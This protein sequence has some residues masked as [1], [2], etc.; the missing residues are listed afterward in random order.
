VVKAILL[1]PEARGDS[2]S[3]PT[4]GRLRHPAQFIAGVP[5]AFAARSA[6]GQTASDGC[7]NPQSSAMGMDV[8][9]PP[10]VFSY[11]SPAGVVPGANGARGPEFGLF[12]TSTALRRVNF[13]NTM[14]FSR[15]AVSA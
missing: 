2:K 5:R 12:T 7:L 10:S 14:V 4:Y 11:F 3:V 13:V 15:I 9:R 8:F 1:D 6:D